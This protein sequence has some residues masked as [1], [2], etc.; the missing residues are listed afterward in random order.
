MA[1]PRG[2]KPVAKKKTPARPRQRQRQRRSKDDEE[3]R[4]EE[5]DIEHMDITPE[6]LKQLKHYDISNYPIP[7]NYN[8]AYKMDGKQ[9]LM[10]QKMILENFK[11]YYGK[12]T[13]GPFH[14]HFSA[15]V[16]ANGSGKSNIIDAL[17]F[18]FGSTASRI[19]STNVKALIHK[20]AAHHNLS[21]CSVTIFFCLCQDEENDKYTM[22]PSSHFQ[23]KRTVN[24]SG[25]SK[26]YY[27]DQ[28]MSRDDLR[29]KLREHG[30]DMDHNRFLILQVFY[31]FLIKIVYAHRQ[32]M[33][34]QEYDKMRYKLVKPV[35]E[36]VKILMV[37]NRLA[38]CKHKLL[39]QEIYNKEKSLVQY[40]NRRDEL[41]AILAS[42]AQQLKQIVDGN[43]TAKAAVT[44]KTKELEE[45]QNTQRKQKEQLDREQMQ[46]KRTNLNLQKAEKLFTDKQKEKIKLED[47]IKK[48][49]SRPAK[50]DT[51]LE[52]FKQELEEVK[53]LKEEVPKNDTESEKFKKELEE[54]KALKEEVRPK[55][56]E[57][58]R[59]ANERNAELEVERDQIGE[60][61]A[62]AKKS[63]DAANAKL[64]FAQSNLMNIR[65]P[66]ENAQRRYDD[67]RRTIEKAEEDFLQEER[68]IKETTEKLSTLEPRCNNANSQIESL[69]LREQALASKFKEC[70]NE[71]SSAKKEKTTL[72]SANEVLNMFMEEKRSGRIPGICGRL[73]DLGNIDPKYDVAISS[74]TKLEYIVTD[75]YET[76]KECLSLLA[77]HP[78]LRRVTF[79]SLDKI[80]DL[81]N[82]MNP[83]RTPYNYPRL[84]DLV[85][86]IKPEYAVAFYF[87]LKNT[88]VC[89][90]IAKAREASNWNREKWRAVTLSGD[91]VEIHGTMTGG[92]KNIIRGK[93][94]TNVNSSVNTM[95][96][97]A[98]ADLKRKMDKY[99]E[100]LNQVH[101]QLSRMM[102][103]KTE[104]TTSYERE[105]N[106]LQKLNTSY[107]QH[108][109][110]LKFMKQNIVQLKADL[111]KQKAL[112]TDEKIENVKNEVKRFTDERDELT[113]EC[114]LIQEKYN[115]LTT[116]IASVYDGIAG[117][118]KA[119]F[120]KYQTREKEVEK[121]LSDLRKA[122]SKAEIDLK[123][124]NDNLMVVLRN[125]QESESGIEK[126]KEEKEES[127]QIIERLEAL[128]KEKDE[129]VSKLE[130]EI[131]EEAEKADQNNEDEVK[132][133]KSIKEKKAECDAIKTKIT[134]YCDK[135]DAYTAQDDALKLHNIGD[136]LDDDAFKKKPKKK[137]SK[138][139]N[140]QS[141]DDDDD[142]DFESD[143]SDDDMEVDGEHDSSIPMEVDNVNID[144]MEECRLT[145]F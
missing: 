56:E 7:Q 89:D 102:V 139:R 1:R 37:E 104:V 91:V 18:V 78:K 6:L 23:V 19:R 114:E 100:E 38:H 62:E 65:E 15:I 68:K 17:M 66:L 64:V 115:S 75:T 28:T 77:R 58:N 57:K 39:I 52:K 145:E 30:I 63:E 69:T 111:D 108:E 61:L 131:K 92:G 33:K 22:V 20:S 119:L 76:T 5:R 128:M 81:S 98:L 90:D 29:N 122:S 101:E 16:G 129:V 50:N 124:A 49:E 118:V 103:E 55:L 9:R 134:R 13:I 95:S 112:L 136:L 4:D 35:R 125:I 138:K 21:H 12:Q 80:Q 83:M 11:S 41:D 144:G 34:V 48:I 96:E 99:E 109:A 31:I 53:A 26:Y 46:M 36:M 59:E 137:K 44:K 2:R 126:F 43:A 72:Q 82:R 130:A 116:E 51:E 27:G 79:L 135:I 140:A 117:E 3:E 84:F 10:I 86:P 14:P 71:Y 97:A 40:R 54:V 24:S 32:L 42:E 88:I 8:A 47:A 60:G 87:A 142:D 123:T 94:G 133:N 113:K 74:T 73:G 141:D 110:S 107:K 70:Q 67:S 25:V 121:K 106:F 85:K 45:A 132:L 143:L 120:D 127:L 105:K 93:I